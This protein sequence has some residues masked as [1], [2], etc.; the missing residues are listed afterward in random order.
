MA[1]PKH[2]IVMINCDP[3]T[4][5]PYSVSIQ[6]NE[7]LLM[8]PNAFSA[9]IMIQAFQRM[10]ECIA[11]ESLLTPWHVGDSGVYDLLKSAQERPSNEWSY[12]DAFLSGGDWKFWL[13]S[14]ALNAYLTLGQAK[15]IVS[16][17]QVCLD[18][19][20]NRGLLGNI[21]CFVH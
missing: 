20:E 9:Q 12:M 10:I 19:L 1:S 11:T 5:E 16:D 13:C 6:V 21:E 8:T 14:R 18:K 7:S 17:F 15:Q 4:G 2:G 3:H